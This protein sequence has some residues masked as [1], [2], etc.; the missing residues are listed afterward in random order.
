MQ[1]PM[2]FGVALKKH[3]LSASITAAR[4]YVL[5]VVVND[6]ESWDT[7]L[8][9]SVVWAY[10]DGKDLSSATVLEVLGGLIE[11]GLVDCFLFQPDQ[12]RYETSLFDKAMASNFW[13]FASQSGK[14]LLA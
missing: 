2:T 9:E 11:E 13:F 4:N 8:N 14:H 10:E 7:V 6:Y 12:N 3:A 1:Y 5:N